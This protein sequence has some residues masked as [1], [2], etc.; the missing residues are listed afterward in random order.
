MTDSHSTTTD[1]RSITTADMLAAHYLDDVRVR[2]RE[3]RRLCEGAFAQVDD[4]E[5]F[6]A[7]DAVSN[8]LALIVKHLSGN[9]RS[10][11]TDFL[12]TDGEKPERRRDTEFV[13][14]DEDRAA[15]MLQWEAGWASLV[16]ALDALA[17]A[18]VMLQTI[19]IRHEPHTVV[20]AINRQLAHYGYHT[21]QIVFLAKHLTAGAWKTLSVARGA[22]EEFNEEMKRQARNGLRE[23]HV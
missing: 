21:G 6:R 18:E 22:S 1:S 15:L 23:P 14:E 12:T 3:L 2:F 17:G 13:S 7:P 9:M 20:A 10:R 11:W 19:T 8:S 4:A 16:T 5:F